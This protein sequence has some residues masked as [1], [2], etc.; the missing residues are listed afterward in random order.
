MQVVDRGVPIARLVSMRG[1]DRDDS[2]RVERLVASGLLRAGN[3][4][5][6]FLLRLKPLKASAADLAGALQEDRE[7]SA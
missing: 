2:G 6:S 3:G 7:G 1:S 4:D 5:A